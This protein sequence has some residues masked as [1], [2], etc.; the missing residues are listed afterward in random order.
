MESKSGTPFRTSE[1]DFFSRYSI[2]YA[3]KAD[4]FIYIYIYIYTKRNSHAKPKF[5][6]FFRVIQVAVVIDI[7]H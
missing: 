3:M 4:E 7:F 5:D 2:Q 6:I 1:S